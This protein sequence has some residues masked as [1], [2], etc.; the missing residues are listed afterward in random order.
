MMK[1]GVAER[2]I[3]PRDCVLA[4]GIPTSEAAFRRDRDDP[5][6][7]Y[8]KRF[9]GGWPHY[10]SQFVSHFARATRA[11]ARLGVSVRTELTL[12][13]YGELFSA[14]QF[15]V[16]ALVS[17][18]RPRAIEL[19]DGFADVESLVRQVPCDFGGV[20]DLCACGPE[21]LT[22]ALRRERPC[23]AVRYINKEAAPRL[24]LYFYLALFVHLNDREL[25]Y[26]KALEDVI[27]E[28]FKNVRRKR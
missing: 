1:P 5:R 2:I 13:Q 18:W 4:F 3:K 12:E 23:C 7:E 16:V 11:L 20:V 10:S 21:A 22:V 15:G 9:A 26:L 14:G 27:A 6:K 17:H 24:W 25:T 8:A 19:H 28:F